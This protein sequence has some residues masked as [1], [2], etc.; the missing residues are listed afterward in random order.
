MIFTVQ[1]SENIQS[2]Q[3]FPP[4]VYP[5]PHHISIVDLS[6][7]RKFLICFFCTGIIENQWFHIETGG[8]KTFP[9]L[10]R[11]KLHHQNV[12]VHF[13]LFHDGIEL[14]LELKDAAK[15]MNMRSML[16]ESLCKLDN[17]S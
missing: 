7:K 11:N 14:Q 5:I 2:R 4:E 9:C 16:Y 1:V 15:Y 8:V 10:G 6:S 12:H 17:I 3:Y 13:S